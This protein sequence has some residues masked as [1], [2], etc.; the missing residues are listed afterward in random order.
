MKARKT[1]KHNTLIT[2][3]ISQLNAR[4]KPK[5]TDIKKCIDMLLEKEYIERNEN[6]KDM[7]NYLA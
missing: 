7:Y 1:L 5:I 2:E 6:E 4:F 3:I